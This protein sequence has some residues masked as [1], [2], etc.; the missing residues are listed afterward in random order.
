MYIKF[1]STIRIIRINY[2]RKLKLIN[3]LNHKKFDI[4]FNFN[5]IIFV[6]NLNLKIK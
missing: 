1:Y 6:L 2:N 5:L 4:Y 3:Y